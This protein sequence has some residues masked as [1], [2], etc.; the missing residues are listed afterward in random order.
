MVP[1]NIYPEYCIV[2]GMFFMIFAQNVENPHTILEIMCS[3]N[4]VQMR[5]GTP[6]RTTLK[7]TGWV[8]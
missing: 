5:D 1:N 3:T 4:V 2:Y 8:Y 7:F 6:L